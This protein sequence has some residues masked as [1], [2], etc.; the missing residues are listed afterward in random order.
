VSVIGFQEFFLS[1]V[2]PWTR[3]SLLNFRGNP[4]PDPFRIG[5]VVHDTVWADPKL[6]V[7]DQ[8]NAVILCCS[9]YQDQRSSIIMFTRF[10][11]SFHFPLTL[12][13]AKWGSLVLSAL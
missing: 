7:P 1:Q 4:N 11:R 5:K 13:S 12:T 6:Y 3:K 2:Y 8:R 9:L 10:S